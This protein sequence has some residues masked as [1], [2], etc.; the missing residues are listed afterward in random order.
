MCALIRVR[1]LGWVCVW[2]RGFFVGFLA[3]LS[4]RRRVSDCCDLAFRLCLA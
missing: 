4:F 2:L 3:F 1:G